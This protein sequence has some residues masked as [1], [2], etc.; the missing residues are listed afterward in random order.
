MFDFHKF[1]FIYCVNNE[2][3]FQESLNSVQTLKIPT[4][5]TIDTKI[6]RNVDSITKG[7]NQAMNSSNAKYKIYLHQDVNI[8]EP[9]FLSDIL[10]LF[11]NYP[12]LGM[13]GVLGAKR[14]PSNGVWW[15]A[16]ERYGK[17]YFFNTLTDCNMEILNEYESVQVIDGMI[18][19]TQYD[20]KW[21][22]DLF[23]G[24]HFYDASQSFEFIKAGYTVGV[25]KQITPWCT[26]NTLTP[27]IPFQQN[28]IIF[29]NEYRDLIL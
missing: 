16:E 29:L 13:L 20:I 21:R 14:L 17:V 9:N 27:L 3:Q 1:E 12:N 24:W 15:N 19:M 23:S 4:G 26:H 18:I 25:P 22:E 8:L 11:K 5:Y 10:S 2:I 7:Y 6:A 28:Q